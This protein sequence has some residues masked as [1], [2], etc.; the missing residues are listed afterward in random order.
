MEYLT[1]R[2]A[3]KAWG[4]DRKTIQNLLPTIK[5]QKVLGGVV[6]LPIHRPEPFKLTCSVCN[7]EFESYN[8]SDI[9]CS[10]KCEKH[11]AG[12][13]KPKTL[14]LKGHPTPYTSSIAVISGENVPDWIPG[15]AHLDKICINC[16]DV[17]H[18][19]FHWSKYCKPECGKE[20]NRKH[21]IK[22]GVE[23][24]CP[25]CKTVKPSFEHE[26]LCDACLGVWMSIKTKGSHKS[27]EKKMQ[28]FQKSAEAK[29][30]RP[31]R[32]ARSIAPVACIECG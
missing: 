25:L 29:P 15:N 26:C 21:N 2:D 4:L 1:I 9:I 16:G 19:A 32:G 28:A 6:L 12:Q 31:H 14:D 3:V 18:N 30:N 17:Y 5:G 11:K 7:R 8:E 13:E 23:K 22:S 27:T 20:F 24:Y 10:P